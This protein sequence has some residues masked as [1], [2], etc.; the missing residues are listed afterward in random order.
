MSEH[1]PVY[2]DTAFPGSM[3]KRDNGEFILRDDVKSMAHAL[4]NVHENLMRILDDKTDALNA[5]KEINAQL[6]AALKELLDRE[7]QDDDGSETL[8]RARYKAR[9]AIAKAEGKA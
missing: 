9:D 4:V 7:W 3:C 2:F 5:E 6:L 8:E 1:T